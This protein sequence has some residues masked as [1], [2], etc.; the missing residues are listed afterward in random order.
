MKMRRYFIPIIGGR[1]VSI[2]SYLRPS[3]HLGHPLSYRFR[4]LG[5][6]LVRGKQ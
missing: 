5:F 4:Y 3:D 1:W 2:A 6:R